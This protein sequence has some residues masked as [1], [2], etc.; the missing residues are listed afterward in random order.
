MADN[1]EDNILTVISA[2]NTIIAIADRMNIGYDEL[3]KD[4]KSMP[5]GDFVAKYKV[6]RDVSTQDL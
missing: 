1:L 6:L 4:V 3:I 5:V 2:V